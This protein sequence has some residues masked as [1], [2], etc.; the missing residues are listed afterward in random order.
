M[1]ESIEWLF[2][3]EL[4]DSY[5][6]E[7]TLEQV[8]IAEGLAVMFFVIS[9][10]YNVLTTVVGSGGVR[11]IDFGEFGRIVVIMFALG[12]YIPL[13][14]FPIKII[15]L[16]NRA[17]QP[18]FQEAVD[19]SRKLGEYTYENGMIGYLERTYMPDPENPVKEEQDIH[20]EE[21]TLWDFLGMALSPLSAGSF[22]LDV[23]AVSLAATVRIIMQALLKILA[24][25]LFVF[26]PYAF[27]ASIL[28]IWRG[29]IVVWFNAFITIYF[30]FVIFNILDRILYFNLFKD[31]YSQANFYEFTVH[32]S[33]ALNIAIVTLYLMP[34]WIA[35]K[36]V[37]GS[38]AGRFLSLFAQLSTSFSYGSLAKMGGF[39]QLAKISGNKKT[40]QG[41]AMTIQ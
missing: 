18:S 22:V 38:D 33:L 15:D 11:P 3:D 10:I 1:E 27:V 23:L 2:K 28:P 39:R 29:K 6:I 24:T 21:L 34:F 30:S 4:L 19:Y 16:I 14:G 41:D 36:V 5:I 13:V 7:L 40:G 25:V 35:G 9:I 12:L 26:G 32:Q 20:A 37:G 17:T 8:V 31:V